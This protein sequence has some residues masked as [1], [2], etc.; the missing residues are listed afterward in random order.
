MKKSL[1]ISLVWDR[2]FHILCGRI[3]KVGTG[4]DDLSRDGREVFYAAWA[5]AIAEQD[6]NW[7][8]GHLG[9]EY[10]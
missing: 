4:K 3:R 6:N 7:E 9:I 8:L 1:L 10:K 2:F 5:W